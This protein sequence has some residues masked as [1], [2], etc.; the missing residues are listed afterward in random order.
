MKSSPRR[1]ARCTMK[2]TGRFGQ[3]CARAAWG[4]NSVV[5]AMPLTKVR[6][7]MFPPLNP[8]TTPE[9]SRHPKLPHPGGSPA[10]RRL[11][12]EFCDDRD[13]LVDH[14]LL[15]IELVHRYLIV[16]VRV[17]LPAGIDT[18]LR[19]L[20]IGF[21]HARIERHRRADLERIEHA[22][23]APEADAH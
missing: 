12:P 13:R 22:L 5:A 23:H 7:L 20:R 3:S 2:R 4:A 18:G 21:A 9:S 8:C 10:A 11:T 16:A 17:E 1:A 15:V 6:R 19:D 14:R